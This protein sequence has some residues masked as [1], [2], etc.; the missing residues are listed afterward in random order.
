MN[1]HHR[2]IFFR[3]AAGGGGNAAVLKQSSGLKN[4]PSA[5]NATDTI[6]VSTNFTAG[7]TVIICVTGFNDNNTT[8]NFSGITVSGTA[9]VEDSAIQHGV[10][11]LSY[12]IAI[13]RATN[14][15]GGN[16][17]VIFSWTG[18]GGGGNHQLSC[19]ID[20]WTGFQA[21]PVDSVPTPKQTTGTTQSI[22][23]AVTAQA[24][25][26]VYAACNTSN[27]DCAG[28]AGP[29][30]GY[31]QTFVDNAGSGTAGIAGYKVLSAAGAQT[32]N[33]STTGSVES[34]AVMVTYKT[35]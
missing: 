31:T 6:N 7:S 16:T 20:E 25:E 1:K 27:A 9:A 14:V 23:S 10:S 4:L 13:W 28:L 3:P 21:S 2:A 24:H 17:Q 19:S 12:R 35:A 15:T 30:A 11:N 26:I 34:D 33:F 32:A 29:T 5:T 8:S 18:G 22:T